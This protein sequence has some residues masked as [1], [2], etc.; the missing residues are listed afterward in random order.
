M[1]DHSKQ[2]RAGEDTP[3][4]LRE[5]LAVAEGLVAEAAATLHGVEAAA[6]DR[7]AFLR[8][9]IDTVPGFVVVKQ[10]GGRFAL[11]NRAMADAYGTTVDDIVG[12]SDYD[13]NPDTAE[14]D[15]FV[16]IDEHVISE[17]VTKHIPVEKFTNR[18]GRERWLQTVKVPLV[19]PDGS[20]H[21]LLAVALDITVQR[22]LELELR[23][24]QKLQAVGQLAGGIAHD[25]N[26][27]LTCIFGGLDAIRAKI[28]EP[29]EHI[30]EELRLIGDS[31]QSAARLTREL[32]AFARKSP[33]QR[34]IVDVS[35]LLSQVAHLLHRTLNKSIRVQAHMPAVALHVEGDFS[36]LQNALLNL[37]VNARD[38][39]PQGGTLS[40]KAELRELAAIDLTE[41]D[42][43]VAPGSFVVI[44]VSDSGVG[45]D[46]ATL[47]RVFEPFFTT[48]A[49]G[50][51]TGLGLSSVYGTMRSHGG[52]ARVES[53]P[54]RGSRFHLFFP[55]A[56]EGS[57]RRSSIPPTTPTALP[58]GQR[59]LVVDDE[60]AIREMVSAGLT[61]AGY[62]VSATSDG[63]E[64]VAMV[65]REAFDLIILDVLMPGLHGV[66]VFA[67]I[68]ARGR[69]IPVL[70]C[71]GF[72][73][74][75]AIEKVLQDPHTA[76][77]LKPFREAELVLAASSL[78][79]RP[80]Q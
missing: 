13:F 18:A 64:A 4:G 49:V 8:R 73:Q 56:G 16:K 12:K 62:R 24:A 78:L 52:M 57:P 29:P 55:L 7:E 40:L 67:R 36:H 63:N 5:R 74:D 72:S 9:V 39:M 65:D 23:Q 11:A 75:F 70:L 25:F 34:S 58:A 48:K 44:T 19:E 42:D 15:G 80:L 1:S 31:A 47:Q 71:S 14:V 76:L 53:E 51:G 33:L 26:N 21:S 79:V 30:A 22:R 60:L 38:A 59:I 46:E 17:R 3:T 41:G 27:L 54:G 45:M 43:D 28:P 77:L 10:S 35:S 2:L 37:A 50:A 66:D 20:C 6:R 68:R 32:L 69:M 61:R